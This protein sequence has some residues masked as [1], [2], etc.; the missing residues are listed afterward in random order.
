[1]KTIICTTGTSIAQGCKSLSLYQGIAT[2]WDDEAMDLEE[3]IRERMSGLDLAGESGRVE[4]SAELHSLHRLNVQP[5]DSV[6]LLATDT[7]D[8]RVCAEATA[9][10][11][12][13]AYGMVPDQIRLH[14][15]PGLQVRDGK[16][17]REEGLVRFADTVISYVENPQFRHGSELIL[18][19]TGGF[20]GVV[21]FLAAIGMIFRIKTVYVFEFSN[22][23]ITLPPLPV[24][25]DLHLYE[26]AA[27]GL[28]YIHEESY[29]HEEE[30]LARI[31]GYQ[32]HE[33]DLFLSFIESA[34]NGMVTLSPL[35]FVLVRISREGT[36]NVYLSPKAA[37]ALETSD[38]LK[39]L[40]LQRLLL[41]VSDPVW[42]SIHIHAV[43]GCDLEVYKPGNVAERACCIT[44]GERVYVCELLPDHD[45]YERKLN[46]F[47]REHYALES[48][49]HWE[50]DSSP[51]EVETAYANT[52]EAEVEALRAVINELQAQ[53]GQKVGD[54]RKK[55]TQTENMLREKTRRLQ[56]E[57]NKK[58]KDLQR[59]QDEL[60]K[61]KLMIREFQQ[62]TAQISP[63]AENRKRH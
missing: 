6:V 31:E 61:A 11:I 35:A 15:I 18:N 41:R 38:G 10:A 19:P 53:T 8:G 51:D 3:E 58:T 52:L 60:L 33:H 16:R 14:Q 21:P 54:A 36:R 37:T 46:G 24:Q 56:A 17:L 26:R 49:T 4:A 55:A 34:E 5:E 29:V 28:R 32:S 63:S 12:G 62:N 50:P 43:Q 30:F 9:S 39:R 1:M 7:A 45:D 40:A 20:K 48:F 13:K 42:R 59:V 27:A 23:L 47:R 44:Q 22:A 2:S 25:F 57:V